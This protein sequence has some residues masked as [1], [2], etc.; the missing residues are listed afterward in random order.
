VISIFVVTYGCQTVAQGM[1]AQGDPAGHKQPPHIKEGGGCAFSD[2][3]FLAPDYL[4]ERRILHAPPKDQITALCAQSTTKMPTEPAQNSSDSL[5]LVRNRQVDYYLKYYQGKGRRHFK[6]SLEKSTAY[7]PY[8]TRVFKEEHI[9]AELAYLALLESNFNVRAYSSKHAA[10]MWQFV[11]AT[12]RRCGLRVDQWIDERLDFEKSTRAAACYLKR[13]Y[14]Q[15]NSWGLVVAAYNSG[16]AP[17]KSLVYKTNGKRFWD[18]NHHAPFKDETVNLMSRLTAAI[19][20]AQHPAAYGFTS[21]KYQ[22]PR[23]CDRIT[24]PEPT[25]LQRIAHHCAC[26]VNELRQLNPALKKDATPPAYRNFQLYIPAGA[27]QRVAAAYPEFGH[28][29]CR[30]SVRHVVKKGETLTCIAQRFKIAP[31]ALLAFN[32]IPN[33]HQIKIGEVL[34]IPSSA[35]VDHDEPA[36]NT[37]LD[38]HEDRKAACVMFPVQRGDTL[39]SIARAHGVRPEQLRRW[40]KLNS[41]TIHP[42]MKLKIERATEKIF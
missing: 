34:F 2:D 40:N 30:T 29:Q 25:S 6:E 14:R 36:M 24:I 42:G 4:P 5:P 41:N 23:S 32:N 22:K 31:Q 11:P 16:E 10:G 38:S 7:L 27:Q 3:F 1:P 39:W 19:I 21:L 9:P 26:T 28:L 17:V 18:I 33:P 13:L 12:A 20:I 15:F 35:T 37:L 8:I